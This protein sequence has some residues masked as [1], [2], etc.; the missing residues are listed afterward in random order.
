MAITRS[1]TS[2]RAAVREVYAR[3]GGWR[4]VELLATVAA[5]LVVACGLYFVYQSKA[6]DLASATDD[7]PPASLGFDR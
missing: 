7:R 1:T 4:G 3:R 5:G 6:F 2:D